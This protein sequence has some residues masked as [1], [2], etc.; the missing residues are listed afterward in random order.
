M[1]FLTTEKTNDVSILKSNLRDY[2]SLDVNYDDIHRIRN[3][4]L[5]IGEKN[6]LPINPKIRFN[7]KFNQLKTLLP[8]YMVCGTAKLISPRFRQLLESYK[9]AAKF[10]PV[11]IFL[12][13]KKELIDGY[14]HFELL[15]EEDCFDFVNSE[16]TTYDNG[17]IRFLDKLS[18]NTNSTLK[19]EIFHI[20]KIDYDIICV[21]RKLRDI[22]IEE[23][24]TGVEFTEPG[25]W[26]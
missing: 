3:T 13:K 8:D 15:A 23:K 21:T 2:R 12:L 14:S 24:I 5:G 20:A 25:K 22:I 18:L 1:F 11:D 6:P 19:H 7:V 16:Y 9:V 10:H 17:D 4:V 26:R